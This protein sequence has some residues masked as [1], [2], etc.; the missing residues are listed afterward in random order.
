MRLSL[1]SRPDGCLHVIPPHPPGRVFFRGGAQVGDWPRR[2]IVAFI[3]PQSSRSHQFPPQS[4]TVNR[5]RL[6]FLSFYESVAEVSANVGVQWFDC[7]VFP[8]E[9]FLCLWFQ[10]FPPPGQTNKP[11]SFPNCSTHHTCAHTR[12]CTHT[13]L[14]NTQAQLHTNVPRGPNFFLPGTMNS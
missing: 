1:G 5:Q 2:E 9:K 14:Y 11:H 3:P 13:C 7:L 12:R 8:P 10:G 4:S 6:L